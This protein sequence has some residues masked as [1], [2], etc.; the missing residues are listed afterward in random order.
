[1]CPVCCYTDAMLL[2]RRCSAAAVL[3]GHCQR[4]A[5]KQRWDEAL[6][7][8]VV[9]S[10]RLRLAASRHTGLCSSFCQSEHPASL[11]SSVLEHVHA[12]LALTTSDRQSVVSRTLHSIPAA[13]RPTPACRLHPRRSAASTQT[14]PSRDHTGEQPAIHHRLDCVSADWL[15]LSIDCPVLHLT[16]PPPDRRTSLP[17]SASGTRQCL[18]RLTFTARPDAYSSRVRGVFSLPCRACRGSVHRPTPTRTTATTPS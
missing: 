13:P 1:M 11:D 17:S 12:V 14:L 3:P 16:H 10:V 5:P 7:T 4:S 18:A 2:V 15:L 8:N 6:R 9:C